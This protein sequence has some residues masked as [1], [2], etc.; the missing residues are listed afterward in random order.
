MAPGIGYLAGY[1]VPMPDIV[2]FLEKHQQYQT[3]FMAGRLYL[4][5]RWIRAQKLTLPVPTLCCAMVDGDNVA[6]L[7]MTKHLLT[8]PENGEVLE[9]ERDKG[10]RSRFAKAADLEELSSMWQFTVIPNY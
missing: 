6:G 4:V 1:I 5:N 10:L 7:V 9:T 3:D 2:H 8:L